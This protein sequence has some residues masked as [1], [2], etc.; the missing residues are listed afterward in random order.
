LFIYGEIDV[1]D[2]VYTFIGCISE[3]RRFRELVIGCG[4]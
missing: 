4:I 1:D 2:Y 3:F